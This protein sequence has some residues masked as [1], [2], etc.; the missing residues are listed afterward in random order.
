MFV[1]RRDYVIVVGIALSIVGLVL[2]GVTAYELDAP[3][4]A[5]EIMAGSTSPASRCKGYE[6][7]TYPLSVVGYVIVPVAI[8]MAVTGV[9]DRRV[10][11]ARTSASETA[12]KAAAAVGMPPDDQ[13]E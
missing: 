9:V 11:N 8:A 5:W 3:G 2:W 10:R 1:R 7:L 12:A 4:K 13:V 6:W